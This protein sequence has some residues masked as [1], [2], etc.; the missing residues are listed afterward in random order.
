[1]NYSRI[2]QTVLMALAAAVLT[3]SCSKYEKDTVLPAESGGITFRFRTA[4]YENEDGGLQEKSVSKTK[5]GMEEPPG[6]DVSV[7]YDRVEYLITDKDGNKVDGIKSKYDYNGSRLTVEGLHEGEYLLAVLAVSGDYAADGA[8]IKS[9]GSLDETWI[10]FDRCEGPLKAEYYYSKTPFTVYEKDT[11]DGK[12]ETTDISGNITQKRIFGKIVFGFHFRNENIPAYTRN[13]TATLS[14]P[15]LYT[16]FSADSTFSGE[17][18]F[19]DI[20]VD[21]YEGCTLLPSAERISGT[22]E[23]SGQTYLGETVTMEY[24]FS[25][26][27]SGANLISKVM[28]D[29]RHPYDNNGTVFYDNI[30]Y[31]EGGFG[32]ILQDD[33][34]KEVYT[35]PAQRSFSTTNLLQNRITEDGKLFLRFY[36]PR[37]IKGVTV[38]ALLP[39]YP[40]EYI[41]LAYFETIPAFADI[42]AEITP[43]EKDAEY[44][45]ESGKTVKIAKSSVAELGNA[46]I[47][48]VCED[49]Y[50]KQ[51]QEI[52]T[53]W[54]ARF[55]LFNGDPDQPDG[56][57]AGNWK[58]IRPVHCREVIAVFINFTYMIGMPEHEE[59]LRENQDILYGNGGR[60]DK[61]TPEK[62]MAQMSSPKNLT[63]GLVHEGNG[64]LGLGS[65]SIWGV[66][67]QAYLQHYFNTYSCEVMFHELGHVMGYNHS[68]SF[69]YG[70]WAQSLMNNFYVNNISRL[71]VNSASYLDSKNNP[72]LY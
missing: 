46:K 57:P 23:M 8:T 59:I 48:I 40:D 3:V 34:P 67:Q 11:P 6:N 25:N 66:Y 31:E 29:V 72:N 63:V 49:P 9:I 33:E 1:M 19:E 55:S 39:S 42:F 27:V 52:K 10:S 54:T 26:T 17:R 28:T 5:N 70:P 47:K 21:A 61:I 62:V 18:E 44:L 22:V 51:L 36:S 4:G 58:G 56:K 38:R 14:S 68:S 64:V 60:E 16:A 41:D 50:W 24:A 30:A 37:E 43:N 71:P 53:N 2:R 12:V 15:V 69:T 13:R 32:K 35:D 65:P 20:A 7:V 45:T